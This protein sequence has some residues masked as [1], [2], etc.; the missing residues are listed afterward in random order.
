MQQRGDHPA[1]VDPE[2]A[3]HPSHDAAEEAAGELR[4]IR[5]EADERLPVAR[6][7]VDLDRARAGE[8]RQGEAPADG[9]DAARQDP[10]TPDGRR[11]EHV[12]DLLRQALVGLGADLPVHHPLDD[13]TERRAGD[14]RPDAL[15][16]VLVELARSLPDARRCRCPHRG[17]RPRS[18]AGSARRRRSRGSARAPRRAGGSPRP[19]PRRRSARGA[20]RSGSRFATQQRGVSV[21][22]ARRKPK[23]TAT[24]RRCL[25]RASA[26]PHAA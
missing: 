20:A 14:R 7:N 25:K 15:A 8:A 19:P 18:P 16:R 1:H 24:R 26:D 10:A 21:R 12:A 4:A 13:A 11:R 2:A 3:A 9:G 23:T 17:P 6:R 22:R 5:A